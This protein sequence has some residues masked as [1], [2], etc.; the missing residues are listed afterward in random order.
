[1]PGRTCGH[2]GGAARAEAKYCPACGQPLS[3]PTEPGAF[4]P[5]AAVGA[6]GRYRVVR[7]IGR[8]GFGE[9]Y[10]A[11]DTSLADRLCVLKRLVVS[12][13][14]TPE[15][16]AAV[17]ELFRR[18]T[19]LLASINARGHPHIPDIYDY[20]PDLECYVLKYVTG[21]S[22][23]QILD[24]RAGGLPE[25]E[26]LA[27]ARAVCSALIY[28]HEQPGLP[29]LHLDISP[30][31]ILLDDT[32]R[33]WLIDFGIAE[34]SD[35]RR[36][37]LTFGKRDY[38]PP[39]QWAGRAEPRSD[40][41][42]LAV[43]LQVLLTNRLPG[44]PGSSGRPA[45]APQRPA[46]SS[47]VTITEPYNPGQPAA[48][49]AVRPD[50]AALLARALSLEP[51]ARPSSR[52]FLEA[53]DAIIASRELPPPP[54]PSRVPIT[55]TPV[56]RERA[57][58][59]LEAGLREGG[60]AV[61]AGPAGI[62]KT[63]L[64][65]GLAAA[66]GPPER[67][68]WHSLRASEGAEALL[69][70][71]AGFL[72]WHGTA[73]PWRFLHSSRRIGGDTPP[74]LMVLDYLIQAMRGGGYLLVLDDLHLAAD[75]PELAAALER[76]GAAA[77]AG[78]LA[79]LATTRR[80]PGDHFGEE[81]AAVALEGLSLAATGV[82]LGR[83]GLALDDGLVERLYRLT[84]GNPQLLLLAAEAL[85]RA[86]DP[87]RVV[88][89]LPGSERIEAYLLR[90]VDATLADDERQ[91]MQAL[92]L[93]PGYGLT[94]HAVEAA[95][96]GAGARRPLR[97]MVDRHLLTVAEGPFGREYRPHA[98]VQAFY[99]EE[100]GPAQRL[101]M[102]RRAGAHYASAEPDPL[103]AGTHY[104]KAG[105][106]EAAAGVLAGAWHAMVNRGQAR[107]LDELLGD[108]RAPG[109]APQARAALELARG[110]V[111][112]LLGKVDAAEAAYLAALAA[113]GASPGPGEPALLAARAHREL[114]RL[115]EQSDHQA[116]LAHIAAGLALAAGSPA[117]EAE[118]LV[119]R[120][121]AQMYLGD[122][123]GAH[124]ALE[125][126]LALAGETPSRLRAAALLNRSGVAFLLGDLP[127][128][129][130]AVEEAL[131]V[132]RALG[133]EY[134]SVRVL[135]N[136]GT[137]RFYG[138]AWPAATEALREGLA[139]AERLGD[140]HGSV[141]LHGT[142]GLCY[143]AMGDQDEAVEQTARA[144]A[145]ARAQRLD[146]FAL[147]AAYRLAELHLRAGDL[148]QADAL[149]AQAEAQ[150]GP[151]GHE[152]LPNVL[153]ARAEWQIAAG[154]PAD[155]RESAERAVHLIGED[156]DPV[157]RGMALRTRGRARLAA[158]LAEA[159]RADLALAVELIGDA[160]DYE[161][162]RAQAALAA[163]LP[164]DQGAHLRAAARERF[165]ELGAR[166]D[167]W[168]L[169]ETLSG[170]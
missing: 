146:E 102:H 87:A 162:A 121:A 131:A 18:E 7:A 9:V 37:E 59:A 150:A 130:G 105:D 127:A 82:V 120:G 42:A 93:L 20:L 35:G 86:R 96:G 66:W 103:R 44:A 161:A 68:F 149:L 163:A 95:L 5:G 152:Q 91:V 159:G 10:L 100:A 115:A 53:L 40:V 99:A 90:E 60:L 4:A 126:A 74:L 29:V 92:A 118:L 27:H 154:R 137:I 77:R 39:E 111:A 36:R 164:A 168:L 72:E 97:A 89:Q 3:A 54:P 147:I 76:L 117:D 46:P 94:R 138:G 122:L 71:L 124:E 78:A 21:Q 116:A 108:L 132:C 19:S 123:A 143:A 140:V 28:L 88:E 101:V 11:A 169:E 49:P 155:A 47:S 6:G 45:P 135:S 1:M 2:C 75:D 141:G 129:A 104:H 70:A 51:E 79:L 148:A 110:R 33:I 48:L 12:P 133:D 23:Q 151:A 15:Q 170:R 134:Q 41:Y 83:D 98:M 158:G 142:L 58:A 112:A 43:T 166:Y 80:R 30:S 34:Q 109:L 52:A 22:L 8:G 85:R 26:A 67:V 13:R 81:G 38:S 136:L 69:W 16:Q 139:L 144:L 167:L 73:G 56:G 64:A 119:G 107:A 157:V 125:R 50:V 145:L 156:D 65:A 128:A 17:R 113:L 14:W 24:S 84:E 106:D 55:L 31:N 63:A 61:A 25:A 57:R 153:C 114:A 62:G 160:D 32:G 165:A